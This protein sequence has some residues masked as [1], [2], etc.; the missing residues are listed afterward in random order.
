M[1]TMTK[2]FALGGIA[3]L[4]GVGGFAAIRAGR[5]RAAARKSQIDD[6]SFLSDLDEPVVVTDEVIVVTEAGPYEV[7]MEL[8]PT[9]D[10]QPQQEAAGEPS[11]FDIPGRGAGPR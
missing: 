11:S 5:R 8:I 3:A 6:F 10:L 4:G 2:L 1:K 9:D 7:D